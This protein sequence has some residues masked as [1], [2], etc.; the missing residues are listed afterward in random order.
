MG[1]WFS[2]TLIRDILAQEISRDL[3]LEYQDY[4]PAVVYLNGEYWGVYTIRDRVD[5]RYVE[6]LYGIDKDHVDMINGN[7]LD[8]QAGSND[9]YVQ[10]AEFIEANDLSHDDNY[11]FVATQIDISNFIDYQVSEMFFANLD[12]PINNQRLWRPQT[13]DGKWRWILFDVDA[14]FGD[15]SFSMLHHSLV[16]HM[17]TEW[18]NMPVSTFLFDNLL[19]N[20]NFRSLFLNRYAEILKEEFELD[21]MLDKLERIMELY[22]QDLPDHISRWNF[23]N[24]METWEKDIQNQ[25]IPFLENRPCAVG[26]NVSDFFNISD[27]G[28]TCPSTGNTPELIKGELVV[29]P[30]PSKGSFFILNNSPG[31]TL[32]QMVLTDINGRIVYSDNNIYLQNGGRKHINLKNLPAGIYFLKYHNRNLSETRRIVIVP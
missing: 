12:W 28:F 15:S 11:G 13:P 19:K 32:E 7:Y 5:E 27:F 14:G 4:Q 2:N 21:K 9:H 31:M 20:E 24:D 18:Q 8:V 17:G 3:D 30:N 26:K 22:R 10:L 1:D 25:I 29:A 16:E 23:P 6:Y